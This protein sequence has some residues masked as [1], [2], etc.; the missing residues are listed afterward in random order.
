MCRSREKRVDKAGALLLLLWHGCT[1]VQRRDE[2]KAD[3]HGSSSPSSPGF[4]AIP[5]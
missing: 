3:V 2:K 5:Q 4:V 1:N